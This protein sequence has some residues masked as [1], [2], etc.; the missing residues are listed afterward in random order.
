LSNNRSQ[1]N[2]ERR[3]GAILSRRGLLF[4]PFVALAVQ[5]AGARQ[6]WAALRKPIRFGMVTDCH[7][8]DREPTATRYYR[9]SLAKLSECV[10]LMNGQR[11]EFL[12]ELGDLKDQDTPPD[13]AR[14]L[15]YLRRIESEFK[16]FRRPRYHVLGNHDMDSI[17]K[18]QFQACVENTKIPPSQ[19]FY[20]FAA[21]GLRGIVLDAAY[22]SDGVDYDKGNF[23]WTD[24]NVPAAQIEWLAK[25]L[26]S[27][28]GP[29]VVF[30]HQ[31]LDGV[32]DVFIKNAAQVRAVLEKSGKVCAAF[33][34]H[35]HEGGYSEINGI[36]YYTLK[37]LVVGSGAEHN[38]YATVEIRPDG[39]LT[40]TGYRQAVSKDLTFDASAKK[41]LSADSARHTPGVDLA[42]GNG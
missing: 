8:A 41:P 38:S 23:D 31:R 24:S 16:R 7:Y 9:D 22:R 42:D 32:G 19:T 27:A 2:T 15:G 11:V 5:L 12:I 3:P 4:T 34:G 14:T 10:D 17:S 1:V 20:A 6:A 37:A 18:A 35:H 26:D 36:H 13:E 40:V 30:V 33:H 39:A 29:V 21:K 28:K 25:Q